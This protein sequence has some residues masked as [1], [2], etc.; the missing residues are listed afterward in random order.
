MQLIEKLPVAAELSLDLALVASLEDAALHAL[1]ASV[2]WQLE[3][4]L[5][6]PGTVPITVRRDAFQSVLQHSDLVIGMAGTAIEQAVGLADPHCS[7]QARAPVH[8]PIR[9]GTAPVAGADGLLFPRRR[10]I[11]REH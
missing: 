3:Q 9:R 8:R 10:W 1:A 2:G 5:S 4:V 6:R 11:Q 7:F